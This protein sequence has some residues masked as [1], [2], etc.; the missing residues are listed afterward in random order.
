[1]LFMQINPSAFESISL[2]NGI[3]GIVLTGVFGYIIEITYRS[4]SNSSSGGRQLISTLTPLSLCVCLI[5]T[6]V[7]GSLALSLGLVGA[8]SI[9]RFRTPIKDPE[10]LLY[11]FLSIV[12]GL[13]FG[14]GQVLYTSIGILAICIFLSIRA[15]SGKRH[16][17]SF[18]K[19]HDLTMHFIWPSSTDLTIEKAID[20]LSIHC[21][22]INLLRF[23]SNSHSCQLQVQVNIDTNKSSA[24][25]LVAS[26]A[27]F[28][29]D[30]E[31]TIS[32]SS[33]I[34]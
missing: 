13:G 30:S 21:S 11:L 14:S 26:A 4:S 20:H 29:D 7:K 5:I 27:S 34:W 16:S 28:H 10:D 18:D 2:V 3:I 25:R 6:V 23:S 24:T 15:R 22:K 31:I 33:L 17:R 32:N 1:M 9:V 8:L 12:A 19:T